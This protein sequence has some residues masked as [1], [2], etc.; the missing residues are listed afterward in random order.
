MRVCLSAGRVCEVTS[1]P[2]LFALSGFHIYRCCGSIIET[3]N[4]A[5][6][7]GVN[8]WPILGRR[9]DFGASSRCGLCGGVWRTVCRFLVKTPKGAVLELVAQPTIKD[10]ARNSGDVRASRA[11]C[12]S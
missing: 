3:K 10:D 5:F 6:M 9:F 2:G 11:V 1:H 8:G 12:S 7:G 4:V